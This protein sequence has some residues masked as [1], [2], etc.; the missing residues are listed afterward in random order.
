MKPPTV[1]LGEMTS[2]QVEAF[3]ES[4]EGLPADEV[5]ERLRAE[6][7]APS[8]FALEVDD[9]EVTFDSTDRDAGGDRG[10]AWSVSFPVELLE[11]P[12]FESTRVGDWLVAALRKG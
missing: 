7:R 10:A 11:G 5:V 4:L 12:E 3:L 6:E 8:V 1:F 2:P 9:G